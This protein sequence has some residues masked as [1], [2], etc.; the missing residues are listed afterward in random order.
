MSILKHFRTWGTG[1]LAASAV[2]PGTRSALAAVHYVDVNGTNATPPYTNWA[3]AA[4]VIQDAVDA[5]TAVDE[6]VVTNGTYANG[7]RD[8][9]RVEVVKPVSGLHQF[10]RLKH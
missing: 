8:G 7:G 5:A 9:N 6:I 2:L 3:A 4:T 10:F 1:S